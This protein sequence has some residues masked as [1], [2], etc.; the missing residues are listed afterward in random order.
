MHRANTTRRWLATNQIR[1]FFDNR[2]PPNS[3]DMN[4]IEHLWP[5]VTRRLAGRVFAGREALWDALVQAFGDISPVEV[6]ALY[7]SMPAR[8]AALKVA[9]GGHTRY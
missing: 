9:N 8:L 4:P 1:V 7:E 2:W 5:M 6:N 3:P